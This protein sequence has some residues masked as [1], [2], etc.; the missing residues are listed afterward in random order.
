MIVYVT[1]RSHFNAGHRLHSPALS[2]AENRRLYGKCNHPSGHGHNYVVELTLRGEVD[3]AIGAFVNA[4]GMRSWLWGEVLEHIDHRNL[5]T[6]VAFMKGIIPTSENL[7]RV[8]FDE[9][10]K[11][12]YGK[13]LYEVRLFESENNIASCRV[14]ELS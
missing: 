5:N 9:V 1:V 10:R 7:A 8:I 6:D 3:P 11:G 4:E 12:E 2:D 13:W 14:A